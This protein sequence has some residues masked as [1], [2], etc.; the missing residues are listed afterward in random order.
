MV[1]WH[2]ILG[3]DDSG[4]EIRHAETRQGCQG[5]KSKVTGWTMVRYVTSW[6]LGLGE[7]MLS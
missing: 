1:T 6:S 4:G 3:E 2:G 7:V 5:H